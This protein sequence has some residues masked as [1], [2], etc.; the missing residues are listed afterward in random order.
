M[1]KYHIFLDQIEQG[2]FTIEELKGR[3][4]DKNTLVWFE[5]QEDWMEASEID[6]LQDLLKSIPPKIKKGIPPVPVQQKL[7]SN[8]IDLSKI[9]P[10]YLKKSFY[11]FLTVGVLILAFIYYLYI[12]NL[13]QAILEDK[14]REENFNNSLINKELDI[15]NEKIQQQENIENERTENE[16]LKARK[17]ELRNLRIEYEQAILNLEYA[18]QE[19]DEIKKFKVLRT[20]DEKQQQIQSQLEII[21]EYEL[22]VERLKK[23]INSF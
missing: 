6:D 4:I 12:N 1:R 18:N 22:Q 23:R 7:K 8:N 21:R 13:N 11:L 20:A 10:F 9:R 2:P 17:I 3:K 14:I 15:Q 16:N 5:G 19:L